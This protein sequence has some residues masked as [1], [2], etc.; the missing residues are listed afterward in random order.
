MIDMKK[1]IGI[2]FGGNSNEYGVSLKSA[3]SVVKNLD[4]DKYNPILIGITAKG[5]WLRYEGTTDEMLENTWFMNKSCRPAFLSPCKVN[6][7]LVELL[8]GSYTITKLDVLFAVMH[9]KNGEDGTM[10]GLFELSGIPYVGCNCLSSAICMDKLLA[11]S[12][13]KRTGISVPTNVSIK[14]GWDPS[15]FKSLKYPLYIKPLKSGSSIG[16]AKITTPEQLRP[17]IEEAFNFDDTVIVE[18]EVKGFEVGCAVLGNDGLIIG[19]VDEIELTGGFFDYNEKYTLE[20]SKIHL[21]ARIS[22]AVKKRVKDAAGTIYKALYCEGLARVD[23]FITHDGEIVFNEVNTIPGFTQN[24]RYPRML[25]E[26]GY[27][28]KETITQAIELAFE[29]SEKQNG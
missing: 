2:I 14:K 7:G 8:N 18:E 26:I 9:G 19:E 25:S 4:S 28:F 6:S 22:E 21:P 27:S 1:N 3:A 15:D 29:R 20:S 13:V 11:H 12:I 5:Q 10:Q 23:M 16:I 17:A 24:S